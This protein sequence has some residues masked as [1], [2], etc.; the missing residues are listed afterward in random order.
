MHAGESSL[1][2]QNFVNQITFHMR[3]NLLNF[4]VIYL[5]TVHSYPLCTATKIKVRNDF[6]KAFLD[7]AGRKCMIRLNYNA[8]KTISRRKDKTLVLTNTFY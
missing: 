1:F 5:K 6:H 7:T 4:L 2:M 3:Y 8:I